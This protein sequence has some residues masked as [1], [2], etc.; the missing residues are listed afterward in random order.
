MVPRKERVSAS[1]EP[2][3]TPEER[4]K[5]KEMYPHSAGYF[6]VFARQSC[7]L[8]PIEIRG[9]FEEKTFHVC[10]DGSPAYESRWDYVDMFDPMSGLAWARRGEEAFEIDTKGQIVSGPINKKNKRW[11]F[12]MRLEA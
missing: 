4:V 6:P 7:E 12:I 10:R 9:G 5:I 1:G 3:W 8:V 11:P 2:F